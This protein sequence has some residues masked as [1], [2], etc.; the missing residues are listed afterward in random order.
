[1]GIG[2]R[3][4]SSGWA[5]I[6]L[7]IMVPSFPRPWVLQSEGAGLAQR[8]SDCGPTSSISSSGTKFKM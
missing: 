1:M 2:G 5:G 4:H 6:R 7:W 8:S 3:G